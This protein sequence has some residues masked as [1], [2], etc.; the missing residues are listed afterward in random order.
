[1]SRFSDPQRFCLFVPAS[2]DYNVFMV[3]HP[4]MRIRTLGDIK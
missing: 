1:M 2:L 3:G 4:A